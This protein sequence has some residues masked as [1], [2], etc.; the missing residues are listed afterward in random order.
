MIL[1]GV[2]WEESGDVD[3][4]GFHV[5]KLPADGDVSV[6]LAPGGGGGAAEAWFTVSTGADIDAGNARWFAWTA[7]S[8]NA[9]TNG[10]IQGPVSGIKITAATA[11]AHYEVLQRRMC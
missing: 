9:L 7:G 2:L 3:A 5:I 6:T 10:R 11:A 1:R 8:V 4:A